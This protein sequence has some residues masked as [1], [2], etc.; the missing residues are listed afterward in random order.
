MN[1]INLRDRVQALV[2][3]DEDDAVLHAVL[4]TGSQTTDKGT[5]HYALAIVEKQHDG[6]T[7]LNERYVM[8]PKGDSMSDT[9]MKNGINR[10]FNVD[11]ADRLA[12]AYDDIDTRRETYDPDD[13]E[14]MLVM[15]TGDNETFIR[16]GDD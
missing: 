16:D 1:P 8:L 15:V 10:R 5:V 12:Q 2:D 9:F 3:D 7:F 4:P 6:R 14:A 11:L 13:D